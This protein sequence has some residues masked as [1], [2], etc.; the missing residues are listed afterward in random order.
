MS[1]KKDMVATRLIV[2]DEVASVD[3]RMLKGG[4]MFKFN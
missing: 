3:K 2:D 4:R 1:A